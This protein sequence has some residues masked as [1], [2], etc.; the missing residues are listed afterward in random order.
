M[1]GTPVYVQEFL[2]LIF[3]PGYWLSWLRVF[4]IFSQSLHT[5]AGILL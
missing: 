2:G 1:F 3:Q 4:M 5:D